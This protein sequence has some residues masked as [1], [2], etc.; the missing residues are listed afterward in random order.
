MNIEQIPRGK[1]NK[2]GCKEDACAILMVYTDDGPRAVAACK[3]HLL[4]LSGIID[5][6][7]NHLIQG[8]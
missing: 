7:V 1:C 6:L 5:S 8:A 3:A 2:N 4:S